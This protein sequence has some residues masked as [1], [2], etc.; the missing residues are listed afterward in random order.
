MELLESSDSLEAFA[1]GDRDLLD[2]VYRHYVGSVEK[3]LRGGFTFT[4]QGDTIR[5]RGIAEPFR[6]REAVQETFIRAFRKKARQAYDGSRPYRPYLLTIARNLIIDRFRRRSRESEL[7]VHLGDMAYQD[8]DERAV[9]ERVGG[10]TGPSPEVSA[11][12][13]QL[14]ETLTEFVGELDEVQSRIL[15]EHLQGP[16]TQHEM[17]DALGISRNDVRKHIRLIRK[18]LLRRLKSRGVIGSLEV[19][20]AM[21]AVTTLIALGVVS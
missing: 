16:K 7:F 11:W 9:L 13:K 10:D 4:S 15:E 5:F 2:E 14:T 3:M 21:R 18:R 20:E 12:R 8:E 1:Q 19:T 17:A 6:L